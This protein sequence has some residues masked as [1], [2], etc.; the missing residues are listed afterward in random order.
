[1]Y[2]AL[3]AL[4]IGG[5]VL[6]RRRRIP[7][8]PLLA[9]GLDVVVSVAL[10]FGQTRYRTTFEVALVL[11]ASVQL[12]W[13]WGRAAAQGGGDRPDREAPEDNGQADSGQGDPGPAAGQHGDPGQPHAIPRATGSPVSP[14]T[15]GSGPVV[16][17]V[18]SG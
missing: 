2:Y 3:V 9:V 14:G 7:V 8:L 6:L 17:P 15:S 12:E 10:T 1:M 11:A 13:L 4:S 5:V 16:T 18:H